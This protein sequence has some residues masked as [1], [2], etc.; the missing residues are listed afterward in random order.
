MSLSDLG[1]VAVQLLLPLGVLAWFGLA[2]AGSVLGYG[3]QVAA[4]G[5]LLLALCL[6]PIWQMPPW[7]TPFSYLAL[8]LVV[9]IVH[10]VRRRWRETPAIPKGPGGWASAL[11]LAAL[12]A[13]TGS[14][15]LS[16]L[17]GRRPPATGIVDMTFPLGPGDYLVANGGSTATVNAHFLTLNPKTERQRAYRGQSYAV[18]LIKIDP[19]GLRASGWRPRDPALYAIFGDPVLAPCAGTVMSVEDG[20]PDMPVPESDTSHLEGNHA[21]LDCGGFGVLLGHFRKGSLRVRGGETVR[22]GQMIA[23]A[24]NSGQS[25]EPHLHIHAQRL[26]AEAA[27]RLSGAPL[28]I[29]FGGRFPV[30]NDRIAITAR[31][32][33]DRRP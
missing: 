7:W 12:G 27:P 26:A 13:W 6:V 14:L 20:L 33:D 16:A 15:G 2:P 4:S 23:E 11:M 8:W 10:F 1:L 24:G 21:L 5:V 3:I 32:S 29:T 18:D 25:G 19:L 31:I 9:I 17:D 28:F 22:I 30:R